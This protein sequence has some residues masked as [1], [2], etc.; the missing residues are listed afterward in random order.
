[1]SERERER[2]RERESECDKCECA[3]VILIY[4]TGARFKR[5]CVLLYFACM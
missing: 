5:A 4:V 1:M 3:K 2:E